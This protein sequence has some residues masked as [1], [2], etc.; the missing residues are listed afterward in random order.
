MVRDLGATFG[1]LKLD[2]PH[3]Q[4]APIWADAAGCRATMR[5][6]PYNG[7]TFADHVISEE[8][9]Q[10]ALRLLCR[11]SAGQLRAL[12]RGSGVTTFNHV[13]TAAHDPDAWTQAFLARVAAI[14]AAGPCPAA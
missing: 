7:G 5:S 9:R 6:F 11:L 3:W 1:P 14:E 8:G 2:L 10:F 12:F 4:A 13:V